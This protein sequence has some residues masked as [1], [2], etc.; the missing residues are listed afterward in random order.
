MG[1]YE[2]MVID[3]TLIVVAP[4]LGT[5]LLAV[6]LIALAAVAIRLV[7][8]AGGAIAAVPVVRM[9]T[10]WATTASGRVVVVEKRA[11]A[12]SALE[13]IRV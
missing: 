2:R 11:R 4:H 6:A 12:P 8:V 5:L 10:A 7:R 3:F 1:E 13:F 9:A